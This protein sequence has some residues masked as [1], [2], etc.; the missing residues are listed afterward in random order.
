MLSLS[1]RAALSPVCPPPAGRHS[2]LYALSACRMKDPGRRGLVGRAVYGAA[3]AHCCA[4][5]DESRSSLAARCA[6]ALPPPR[7]PPKILTRLVALHGAR[8]R[9]TEC[10]G[11]AAAS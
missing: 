10:R 8:S 9:Q 3:K 11:D 7:F 4:A 5:A 2:Y 1:C 6:A